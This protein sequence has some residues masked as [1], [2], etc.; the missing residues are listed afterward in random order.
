MKNPEEYIK[1]FEYWLAEGNRLLKRGDK[2]FLA[3]RTFRAGPLRKFDT[4]LVYV[5]DNVHTYSG[6]IM[7]KQFG[8][9]IVKKTPRM[10][11]TLGIRPMP[12]YDFAM[13]LIFY[14]SR[15][16]ITNTVLFSF[17]QIDTRQLPGWIVEELVR[18][19]LSK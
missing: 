16:G 10:L 14:N 13:N 19:K 12:L 6:W 8:E 9:M 7:K 3:I 18:Q 5:C 15:H 17:D 11:I 2:I 1:T 4:L